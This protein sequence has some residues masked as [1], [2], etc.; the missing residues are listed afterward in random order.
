MSLYCNIENAYNN[1]DDIDKLAREVNEN[2]KKLTN[3]VKNDFIT[4]KK[5]IY[6]TI[7]NL[8]KLDGYELFENK[9]YSNYDGTLIKNL[10]N[11]N[12]N[13][14]NNDKENNIDNESV[15]SSLK[16]ASSDES[17]NDSYSYNKNSENSSDDY[18]IKSH[19]LSNNCNNFDIDSISNDSE[20]VINHTKNCKR[21]KSKFLNILKNKEKFKNIKKKN[22]NENE[23]ENE[24]DEIDEIK[25]FLIV[26]F[27]CLVIIFIVDTLIRSITN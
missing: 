16:S 19:N 22:K 24:N 27:L 20:S 4:D 18:S 14:D 26:I 11:N 12:D 3:D 13:N 7:E 10:I 2:R 25:E 8:K 1:F 17:Y 23:N 6:D 21:C 15:D 9:E 5:K